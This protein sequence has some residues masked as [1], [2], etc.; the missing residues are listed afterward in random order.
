MPLNCPICNFVTGDDVSDAAAIALLTIHGHTHA[1]NANPAP[2][3]IAAPRGPKLD[4]PKVNVGVS[5][6]EWNMFARRWDAY[7]VGSSLDPNNC[8]AQLF[9]CAKEELG[10]AL[11]KMDSTIVSQPTATLLAAMKRLAVIAVAPGV[12]RSELMQ[13]RQDR[14]Q[15]FR[16]FAAAVHGKAETCGYRN[17]ECSEH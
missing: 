17:Q 3:A 8:S 6:E 2:A 11:L 14:D 7:V 15:T 12:V 5:L 9:Q 10:N 13:M 16:T 4:R 1:P